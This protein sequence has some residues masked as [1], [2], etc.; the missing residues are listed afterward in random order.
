MRSRLRAWLSRWSAAE[1]SALA[2]LG[3]LAGT[4]FA[5]IKIAGEVS[6]GD[7]HGFDEAILRALRD[8]VDAS[9]PIG[10]WWLEGA[11]RDL[12]A[13]GSA[14]VLGLVTLAALGYLVIERKRAAA[15]LVFVSI[16][17]GTAVST[18]L[19]TSF[20]RP[21]PSLV[22]PLVDV[23]TLSFPSGHAMLSA[24]TFLTLGALLA[25]IQP[26]RRV[27]L[28]LMSVAIT[29]TLVVGASRVYLGVHYPT[30]VLA[31]WSAGATWAILCCL[32]AV[33]LQ[34]RG[35]VERS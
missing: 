14:A 15:V 18:L 26:R 28:Y 12:T 29:L 5:F 35:R 33:W 8:P 10:P 31:G 6:E 13:L 34:R 3:V 20:A 32:V 9:D 24:V 22:A 16:A 25:R 2:A 11:V 4:L 30:D 7:T 27:K 1:L 19:K 21:R 23:Q 17:G